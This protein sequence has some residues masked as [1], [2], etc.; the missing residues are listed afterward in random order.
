MMRRAK[1]AAAIA[2][3]VCIVYVLSPLP[4]MAAAILAQIKYPK[5]VKEL[6]A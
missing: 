4:V 1:I 2:A 5:R 3:L 6:L